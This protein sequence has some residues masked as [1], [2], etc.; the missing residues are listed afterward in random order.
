[1]PR[2]LFLTQVLPYP[3]DAGPKVRAYHMLRHLIRRNE[4]TLISFVRNDDR[5]EA[6]AHLRALGADVRTVLMQRSLAQN[7]RV[8]AK[9]LAT[10]QPIIAARDETV[11]MNRMVTETVR[12]FRP[13][14]VQA[15]QLSMAGYGQSAA[16]TAPVRPLAL[17]DE[18]NAIYLLAT[19]RRHR[20]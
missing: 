18:H 10:G 17:L 2:V 13:N 20:A 14:V 5:P 8:A 15:D 11:A 7:L 3:L 9:G 19:H 12:A 16:R 1:M 4:V 6:V